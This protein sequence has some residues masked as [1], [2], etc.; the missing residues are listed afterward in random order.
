MADIG[1]DVKP[2]SPLAKL[3]DDTL[4]TIATPPGR[5]Y[6]NHELTVSPMKE[7]K[8]STEALADAVK[9]VVDTA[10]ALKPLS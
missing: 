1:M 9:P 4:T 3:C 2:D 6:D 8:Q 5:I 10:K 7:L